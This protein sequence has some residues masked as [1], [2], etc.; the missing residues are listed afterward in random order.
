MP[1]ERTDSIPTV[2]PLDDVTGNPES[3]YD[4]R[5]LPWPEPKTQMYMGP[6][7]HVQQA[8]LHHPQQQYGQ[9]MYRTPAAPVPVDPYYP[10]HGPV[11]H[12][13]MYGHG[14]HVDMPHHGGPPMHHHQGGGRPGGP[15]GPPRGD[16]GGTWMVAP[17]F[18][19][20]KNQ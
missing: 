1:L 19:R 4:H 18:Y 11:M 3:V 9:Q 15:S 13:D 2:I 12:G 20:R 5:H 6:S 8:P 17:Y 7:H 14:G 10:D 16:V